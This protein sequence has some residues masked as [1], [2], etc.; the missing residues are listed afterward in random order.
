MLSVVM[1]LSMP[2]LAKSDPGAGP[3]TMAKL[4]ADVA[5]ANQRLQDLGAQ[6]EAEQESVNKSL[7]EL[8]TARDNAAAAQRDVE[9]SQRAVTDA[10]AAIAA[11]QK[12]FDRFAVAAYVNGPSDSYLNAA[13]PDDI[14]ATAAAG[15]ALAASSK[16]VMDNLQRARTAASE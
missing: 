10:S 4:I 12:R 3:D 15:Q 9:T 11:A 13:S 2:G 7:V 6:I 1:L 14:I 8:E 5:Q 16:Q